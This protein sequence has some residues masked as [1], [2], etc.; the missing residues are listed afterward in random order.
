[1]TAL[2]KRDDGIV[3]FSG[4]RC[5]G[6]KSCV[7]ACADANGLQPDTRVDSLHQAPN[8]LNSFT[9][10]IIKL[11]KPAD[12]SPD[13]FVKLQCMHCLDPACVAA[14]EQA[15]A[16][17]AFLGYCHLADGDID[18]AEAAY[19]AAANAAAP[20]PASAERARALAQT[21]G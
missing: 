10:N 1:M 4:D 3:D 2:Y 6:C 15:S 13:S 12:H 11:Y 18:R 16:L 7:V 20:E 9:K 8:D 5:I 19:T 14:Y 21:C 17:L